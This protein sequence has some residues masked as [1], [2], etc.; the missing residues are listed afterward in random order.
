MMAAASGCWP[1]ACGHGIIK[2]GTKFAVYDCLVVRD[3]FG[4]AVIPALFVCFKQYCLQFETHSE[5]NKV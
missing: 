1:V 5:N 2:P 4:S 3:V